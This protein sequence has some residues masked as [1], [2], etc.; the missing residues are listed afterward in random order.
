MRYFLLLMA[1]VAGAANPPKQLAIQNIALSVYEDGPS[2]PL[3]AEF[4]SGEAIF[5]SFQISGYKVPEEE[6]EKID[7]VYKLEV[8]DFE[9]VPLAEPQS[10]KINA[11]I[12]QEDK[13]WTPK[14][15]WT[16]A[17]PSYAPAG[18]YKIFMEVE[19]RL[20]KTSVKKETTFA[21]RGKAFERSDTL[22]IRNAG[23]YRSEQDKK[24]AEPAAF[25]P[26]DA[27][28]VRFDITGYKLGE[29]NAF[30]A[31]YGFA[32]LRPN[33]DQAFAQPEAALEKEATFYPRRILP[34]VS[35][36]D[37]PKDAGT[38][39]YTIVLTAFDKL[40]N[41]TKEERKTFTIE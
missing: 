33:G 11:S 41:K 6:N 10:N 9:G 39:Q 29:K 8:K 5:F 13:N 18:E 16:I 38:G 27:L 21:I 2:V 25:K 20:A 37:L 24:P 40:G 35:S 34:A 36:I 32:I 12:A 4:S 30:E 1:V 3:P 15:R 17:L 28:W 23:F 14:V 31:G 22:V 7:L 19:D 26:G